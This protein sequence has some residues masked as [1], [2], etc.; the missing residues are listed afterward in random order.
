MPLR[1]ELGSKDMEGGVVM[2]ARRDTGAKEALAWGNVGTHV[3]ALLETI[4]TEMLERARGNFNACLERA[5]NWEGFMAA[6]D[7][8]HMVLAPWCAGE[9]EEEE[10]GFGGSSWLPLPV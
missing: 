2:T 9:G 7:R 8:K 1:L 10:R 3:P 4:Q 5:T 6:L